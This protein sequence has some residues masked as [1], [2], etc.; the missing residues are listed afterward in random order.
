M[1]AAKALRRTVNPKGDVAPWSV[2][3]VIVQALPESDNPSALVAAT[4]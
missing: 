3:G 4:L 1:A 2:H